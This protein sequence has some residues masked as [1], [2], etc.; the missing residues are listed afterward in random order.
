M[1]VGIA[2]SFF[3]N[4]R[5]KTH[6]CPCCAR[7]RSVPL[8]IDLTLLVFVPLVLLFLCG[9]IVVIIILMQCDYDRWFK[10]ARAAMDTPSPDI[11]LE[12][13]MDEPELD[14]A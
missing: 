9:A 2:L 11:R 14:D 12:I 3:E 8:M 13:E 4:C 10:N 5:I 7:A 6:T 1:S